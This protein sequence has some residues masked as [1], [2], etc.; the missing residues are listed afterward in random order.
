M[1]KVGDM[2]LYIGNQWAVMSTDFSDHKIGSVL[3][4][5][6]VRIPI[7]HGINY[8]QIPWED[9]S[10]QDILNDLD[11]GIKFINNNIDNGVLVCCQAGKSRSAAMIIAYMMKTYGLTYGRAFDLLYY[12][13]PIIMPNPNFRSQLKTLEK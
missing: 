11:E 8:L 2:N 3:N 1:N 9:D 12:F 7:P 10:M 6:P 13:R 5:S 4:V